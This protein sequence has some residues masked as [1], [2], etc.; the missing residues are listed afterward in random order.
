MAL[1]LPIFPE[2]TDD[3]INY[4]AEAVNAYTSKNGIQK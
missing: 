2:M 3:Q 4:V 1:S